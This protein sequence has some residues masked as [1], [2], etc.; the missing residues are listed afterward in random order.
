MLDAQK[1]MFLPITLQVY[2][3]SPPLREPG[4]AADG[5]VGC[6]FLS[7]ASGQ[8][9]CFSGQV[10]VYGLQCTYCWPRAVPA[11]PERSAKLL[12]EN[13]PRKML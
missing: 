8:L 4:G 1:F 7:S 12:G 2:V 9:L 5:A 10:T 13:D 3:P 11:H 6:D